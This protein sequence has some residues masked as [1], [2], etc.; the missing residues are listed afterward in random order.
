[1]TFTKEKNETS[2][3]WSRDGTFFVFAS[4]RDAPSDGS[5]NQ[6][7]LMRPDGGEGRRITDAKDGVST[8]AFSKDGRWLAYR[9]GKSGE[10]QLWRLPVTGIDSA[11]PEQLTKRPAGVGQ[12]EW[13][14]DS[15]R[16]YFIAPD[17]LD[18]DDKQRREKRFTVNVRNAETPLASLWALE[19]DSAQGN[20]AHAGLVHH[21]GRLHDLRRRQVGRL[22]RYVGG[23]LRAR[24]HGSRGSTRTC[25]C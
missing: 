21:G 11:T 5:Q 14:P 2:P 6:L 10:E 24:H 17:T 19:L 25:T 18:P 13:A 7:Y 22:P 9:A 1:M 8:F 15:R 3:A 20:A 12:W 16:I 4:N 23:P